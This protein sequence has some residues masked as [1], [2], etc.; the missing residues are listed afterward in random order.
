MYKN[1]YY[2]FF[3]HRQNINFINNN[4]ENFTMGVTHKLLIDFATIG[5][6]SNIVNRTHLLMAIVQCIY[7]T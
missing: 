7:I 2:C 6:L 5:Q 1:N 3:I 4:F